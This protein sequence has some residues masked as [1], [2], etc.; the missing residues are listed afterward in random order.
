MRVA[1]GLVSFGGG[2][3]LP[4]GVAPDIAITASLDDERAYLADPYKVLHPSPT[5][6]V[7]AAAR[8]FV[9]EPR[10]NETELIRE[11][12]DGDDENRAYVRDA[13]VIAA[14]PPLVADPVLAR[15][16]DLLKGL[17]VVEPIRP[18]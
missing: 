1:V 10:M 13:P 11:H 2:K 18:G 14:P 16:L 3:T 12:R 6:K 17:A 9:D 5:A 7:S 8:E 15:A 4:H